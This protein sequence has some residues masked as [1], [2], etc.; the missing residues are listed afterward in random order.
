MK[1]DIEWTEKLGDGV[2]RKIRI[3]FMGKTLMKWQTKRSDEEAWDYDTPPTPED[4]DVIEEKIDILYHRG[5]QP[6]KRIE[7]IKKLRK[8]AEGS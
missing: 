4:W 1:A 3:T 8:E 7:L 5:R 6:Y 2:K